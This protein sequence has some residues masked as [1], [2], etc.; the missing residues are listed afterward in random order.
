MPTYECDQKW[1]KSFFSV[2][3]IDGF[4]QA[5]LIPADVMLLDVGHTLF[6]WIGNDSLDRQ[7]FSDDIIFDVFSLPFV[8]YSSE[9]TDAAS[10][11]QDYLSSD[12][13]GRDTDIPIIK[14]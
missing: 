3:E 4:S 5:D 9:R 6:L 7:G 2:E 12:P 10:M 11:T 1:S 13:S 14:V 8:C